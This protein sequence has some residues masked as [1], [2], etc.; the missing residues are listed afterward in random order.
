MRGRRRSHP[1]SVR[2][3]PGPW[4][5]PSSW[6]RT[7]ILDGAGRADPAFDR[8]EREVLAALTRDRAL[9]TAT[10]S[11]MGQ[12]GA[13]LPVVQVIALAGCLRRG[14]IPPIAGLRAPA[15][16]PLRPL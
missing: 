5:W 2:S 12:L 11:A 15:Q 4:T 10:A 8:A 13:A 3:R 9:L 14:R 16:A 1:P 7:R 6:P